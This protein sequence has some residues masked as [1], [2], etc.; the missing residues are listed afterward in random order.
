M[1]AD[2]ETAEDFGS[3]WEAGWG[4][5]APEMAYGDVNGI[6]AVPAGPP[7]QFHR[8]WLT[9]RLAAVLCSG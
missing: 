5:V 9:A 2:R 3:G 6:F 4:E 8:L 1:V 7:V